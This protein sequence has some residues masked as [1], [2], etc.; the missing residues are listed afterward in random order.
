[1]TT[2][3]TITFKNCSGPPRTVTARRVLLAVLGLLLAACRGSPDTE[4]HSRRNVVFISIDDL[5]PMLGAYGQQHMHAPHLDR[6]ADEGLLFRRAF[7]QQAWCSPSRTSLLTGL[8]PD[9]TRVYDLVTHFR[10]TVPDVVTLPQY[11]K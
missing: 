11:F 3:S 7:V 5:R 2:F 8:R 1:M 4:T 6:L 10:E 9:S